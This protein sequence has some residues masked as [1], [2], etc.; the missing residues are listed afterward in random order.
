MQTAADDGKRN[1]FVKELAMIISTGMRTD[2]PAYFSEWFYNRI[3]EG[4][5]LTRN[6][7]YPGQVTRYR[8]H[9]D[10]V[11][12]IGFCTKNPEPMLDRIHEIDAFHQFWFVT[13]TPYGKEI[14]PYVP[15]KKQ[16]MDA[17]IR[18]SEK[19][20]VP[21]IS[22]RYD[23][24]FLT[25]RYDLKYH[26]QNFEK[27]ASYLSGSVD[28]CVI[29][30]IDLYEKTKRNFP[31]ARAVNREERKIL[32]QEFARI[33]RNYGI[34]I[35]TCCEGTEL[36]EY[37]VDVS[38]C[39]TQEILERAI[40]INMKVP[41]KKKSPRD[42]CNC[43]LGND[44]GMYNTC[45]HGCV[46]CYANYDLKTVRQNMKLHDPKSPFLIGGYREGDK[47]TEAKQKTY[48]DGQLSLW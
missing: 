12:C 15:N 16:V 45:G 40:G 4:Y 36:A 13:I 38:G 11:D 26:I 5:V 33:G 34:Q 9:P 30:F 47:I 43:L 6:P 19:V 31:Q 27:I 28:Q 24:I 35:R 25:E 44:I 3:K 32:G 18:L 1:Y 21:S 48:I 39:M 17:F 23:P 7:Y 8:L 46:Y 22:W 41:P 29:S 20:G 42:A 10:I 37:G 2:I 14:E